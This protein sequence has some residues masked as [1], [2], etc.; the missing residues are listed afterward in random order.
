[1]KAPA[2]RKRASKPAPAVQEDPA[3]IGHNGA[4]ASIEID[5]PLPTSTNRI[6]RRG[7]SRRT[8]N[9]W[10][11]LS[12]SYQTWKMKAGAALKAQHPKLPAKIVG[13][14]DVHLV[15][16]KAKRFKLDLDNRIK[17]A[18]DF[19]VQSGLI[20]DDKF[21]NRV[22]VEW[23]KAPMGARLTLTAAETVD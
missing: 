17:S 3:P 12:K 23:G 2:V 19:C 11:Y 13:P 8:G 7:H 16:T 15:I 20:E 10:T 5:L 21:Q 18:V 9:T 4:P 22:V 14:F 1:M 6:W